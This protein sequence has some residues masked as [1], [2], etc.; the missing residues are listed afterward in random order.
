V[1]ILFAA[2][3]K[4]F[5]VGKN[6]FFG[7]LLF[8]FINK[9]NFFYVNKNQ[10]QGNIYSNKMLSEAIGSIAQDEKDIKI[11]NCAWHLS[12]KILYHRP[13]IRFVDIMD[14]FFLAGENPQMGRLKESLQEGAIID[15]YGA[16]KYV[17][18]SNYSLC[19]RSKF[20]SQ[21]LL[22]PHFELV[23]PDPREFKH[24]QGNALFRIKENRVP[25]FIKNIEIHKTQFKESQ[26][27]N[28][29]VNK[30]GWKKMIS[31]DSTHTK[32]AAIYFSVQND[33]KTCKLF[34]P[35]L[36]YLKFFENSYYLGIGGKGLPLLFFNGELHRLSKKLRSFNS[37]I[38]FFVKI[39]NNINDIKILLCPEK[40]SQYLGIALSFWNKRELKKRCKKQPLL[41]PHVGFDRRKYDGI[42]LNICLYD[43]N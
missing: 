35:S 20:V 36:E 17:F 39:P 28:V 14:P 29:D 1:A 10:I 7:F 16:I 3:N 8:V 13:D 30:N 15:P 26:R 9:F 42:P 19:S 5:P 21:M 37:L 6:I 31:S 2:H 41:N 24:M 27:I 11:F 4:Y 23:H 25:N 32:E 22:D 40:G 12:P 33:A 34:R 38:N 18:S 43:I